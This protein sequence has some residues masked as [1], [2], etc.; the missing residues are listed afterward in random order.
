VAARNSLYESQRNRRRLTG[1]LGGAVATH[2]RA[3]DGLFSIF[4]PVI[5]GVLLWGG[6]FLRDDRP[7]AL[8]PLRA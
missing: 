5:L 3:S 7:R 8:I 6:L 1:Y 2:V 4:F